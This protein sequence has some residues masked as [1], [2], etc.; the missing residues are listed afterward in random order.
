[1]KSSTYRSRSRSKVDPVDTTSARS[2]S[3]GI[4]QQKKSIDEEER[5]KEWVESV[6][7]TPP[8]PHRLPLNVERD[9]ASYGCKLYAIAI[10][11][12]DGAMKDR[13]QGHVVLPPRCAYGTSEVVTKRGCEDVSLLSNFPLHFGLYDRS[14][15]RGVY[16]EITVGEMNGVIALGMTPLP[17]PQYRLPGWERGI[18]LHFDDMRIFHLDGGGRDTKDGR[19]SLALDEDNQLKGQVFGCGYDYSRSTIFFTLNGNR[20]QDDFHATSTYVWYDIF[21]VVGVGGEGVYE[22]SEENDFTVNFGGEDF[23]W[24]EANV[25]NWCRRPGGS[26]HLVGMPVVDLQNYSER[27]G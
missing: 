25:D 14:N 1:V 9:I 13:F 6:G 11:P 27:E 3:E 22:S 18:G 20:L 21:A 4:L 8:N 17:F 2:I 5:A 19:A 23:V 26:F 10:P 12:A 7:E 15:L 24:K 16:Y